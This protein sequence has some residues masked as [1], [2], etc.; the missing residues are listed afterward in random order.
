MARAVQ[1]G[2]PPPAHVRAAVAGE[3]AKVCEGPAWDRLLRQLLTTSVQV[4]ICMCLKLF[5]S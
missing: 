1:W 4:S 2:P 5:W 3:I